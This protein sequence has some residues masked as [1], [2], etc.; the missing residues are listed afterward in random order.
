MGVN[1]SQRPSATQ[2]AARHASSPCDTDTHGFAF[3]DP[4]G[5]VHLLDMSHDRWARD[6]LD[7]HP[8]LGVPWYQGMGGLL[9]LG[10][11]RVANATHMSVGALDRVSD[12]AWRAVLT[13]LVDCVGRGLDPEATVFVDHGIG[14]DRTSRW[15]VAGFAR[16]FGGR[17][18]EDAVFEAA[19]S[20]VASDRVGAGASRTVTYKGRPYRLLWQGQTKYGE[21][22]HLQFVDGSKDFWVD[23]SLVS[24]ASGPRPPRGKYEC[25]ECGEYVVPG[26]ICW[27]TGMRH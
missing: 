16:K 26:T 19:L 10:W 2:V 14:E 15:T 8:E 7:D 9:S 6:Y 24:G 12:A 25:D 13:M 1:M 4:M 11:I 23:A 22:A 17:Q 5:K 20:R 3:V 18:Y 27:E 21:R